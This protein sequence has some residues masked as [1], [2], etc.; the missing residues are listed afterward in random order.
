MQ[1]SSIAILLLALLPG[2]FYF[3]VENHTN[4]SFPYILADKGF[5]VWLGNNRGNKYSRSHVPLQSNS[6][7]YSYPYEYDLL[8]SL[9]D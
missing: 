1:H 2:A 7:K 5:E 8:Y 9:L 4:K 6:S 3:F